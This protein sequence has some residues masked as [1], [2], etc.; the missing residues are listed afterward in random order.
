M[1]KPG[2]GYG[3]SQGLGTA[4]PDSLGNLNNN[5]NNN[6]VSTPRSEGV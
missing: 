1:V 2:S 5:N 4:R 3:V 6:G